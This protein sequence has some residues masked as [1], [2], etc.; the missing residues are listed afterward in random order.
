LP[1]TEL[2][3]HQATAANTT[4]NR[5]VRAQ[6]HVLVRLVQREGHLAK[7]LA[8]GQ[9]IKDLE[10]LWVQKGDVGVLLNDGKNLPPDLQQSP[11]QALL[12]GRYMYQELLRAFENMEDKKAPSTRATRSPHLDDLDLFV[13][14]TDIRGTCVVPSAHGRRRA[15][16]IRPS[17]NH[18]RLCCPTGAR[19]GKAKARPADGTSRAC[20]RHVAASR[21]GAGAFS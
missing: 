7:A 2:W 17:R 6:P 19:H 15:T 9:D 5:R 10:N 4:G 21:A 11:P 12:S 18:C 20:A 14:T 8:N 16:A 13:T 1:F 3:P